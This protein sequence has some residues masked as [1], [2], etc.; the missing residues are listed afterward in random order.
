M[1]RV[2][3][4]NVSL[5]QLMAEIQRRKALLASLVARRDAMNKE[6]DELQSLAGI[7][8]GAA[9][10]PRPGRVP[11]AERATGKTLAQYVSEALAA[12]RKG[13]RIAEIQK[14][15]LAAG[16]PT[17][18]KSLYKALGNLLGKGGFKRVAK[19]VY[20]LKGRAAGAMKTAVKTA[21]GGGKARRG[22]FPQTSEQFILDLLK[23]KAATT[24]EINKAWSSAGRGGVAAPT[25]SNLYKAGRIKREP[26]K[27][28]KGFTYTAA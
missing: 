27:G 14:A 10:A 15:V 17:K 12:T 26:L 9:I 3:L 1:P 11:R 5:K 20:K 18:A 2:K 21:A 24:R 4:S 7:V 28:Q 19:G 16:Y 23:G 6:I 22:K 8:P 25:L 13:L